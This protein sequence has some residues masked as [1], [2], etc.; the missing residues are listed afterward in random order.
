VPYI[1]REGVGFDGADYAVID[2]D[3]QVTTGV[4]ILSTAGHY[5]LVFDTAGGGV[6]VRD[7]PRWAPL[8]S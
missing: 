8:G 5:F 3:M 1:V 4:R 7:A 2:G 6:L